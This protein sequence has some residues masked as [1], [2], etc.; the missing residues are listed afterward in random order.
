MPYNPNQKYTLNPNF[1]T[2]KQEAKRFTGI[3]KSFMKITAKAFEVPY[4]PNSEPYTLHPQ[5]SILD[6]VPCT[7]SPKPS[8]KNPQP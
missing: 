3:D 2:L 6:P 7:L 4:T 8:S 1:R 5:L